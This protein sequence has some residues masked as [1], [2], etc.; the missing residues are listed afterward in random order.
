MAHDVGAV[1]GM[2]RQLT[3]LITGLLRRG[4]RV[5]VISRRCDIPSH[6]LL[7]WIRVPGPARPFPIA[8][9]WFLIVGT[10][11]VW[12]NRAGLL[13]TTGAIILNRADVCTVHYCHYGARSRADVV[14]ERLSAVRRMNRR[15]SA[16]LARL[17]EGWIYRSRR[18]RYFVAVSAGVAREL[19]RNFPELTPRLMVISN[20]IDAQVFRPNAVARRVIRA[21]HDLSETDL[22]AVFVGGDWYWK[23]LD[24]AIEA[25]ARLQYWHVLVV[26]SGEIQPFKH[27]AQSLGCDARVH[28]IGAR[29]DVAHYY[30]A[31]DAFLLPTT[32]ET[33]SLA[34]YEAAAA[35]LPLLVTRVS[36]VEE[37]LVDGYNGWFIEREADEIAFRLK[38]L[39][40]DRD[41]R[42]LMA[43]R[44]RAAVASYSWTRVVDDYVAVYRQLDA[45]HDAASVLASST[46]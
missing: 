19:E 22:V 45:T 46:R 41:V 40:K 23:G 7:R 37:I 13:H 21:R 12:R 42:R 36:G 11:L 43:A 4:H 8:Y 31:A 28:F 35:G 2:E 18:I 25:V 24:L 5:T 6:P 20:A 3:E 29:T 27:L 9:L 15:L 33:F 38:S 17:C 14:C 44:S 30:A 1:G 32:Y 16:A 26:G 34:T 10:F 39:A